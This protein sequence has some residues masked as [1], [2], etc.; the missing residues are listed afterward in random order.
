MDTNGK[1]S[2]D[3]LGQR[4]KEYEATTRLTLP[5]RSYTIIRV[6]GKAFHT[7]TKGLERPFD[8][9][10][11]EDM[12]TTAIALCKN[13][14]GAEFA[15]VQ[16]DEIS[17]LIN[18]F[19]STGTQAWYGNNLQKM[20]S[21]SASIATDAFNRAR[22]LRAFKEYDDGVYQDDDG[23]LFYVSTTNYLETIKTALFDSRVFQIPQLVEVENYFIWRQKDAVRNSIS[24]VAQSMYSHKELNGKSSKMQQEMIFQKGINWNDYDAGVKRGR[25]IV[26]EEYKLEPILASYMDAGST[27]RTR[28]VAKGSLDFLKERAEFRGMIPNNN[29]VNE[30]TEIQWTK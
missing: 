12:N 19:G 11:V 21:V 30:L 23:A 28:W 2:K 13:I 1:Y 27:T 8:D 26:K 16:S 10:L 14:M 22:L 25:L 3:P 7:Y 9:G 17:V 24:S 29:V 4:M 6:D 15:Y 18:D 20:C 5:R